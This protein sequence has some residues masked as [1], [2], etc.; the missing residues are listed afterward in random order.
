MI[1][2]KT[3]KKLL[4]QVPDNADVYAYEGEDCGIVFIS[5]GKHMFIRA[6][7][8]GDKDAYTEGFKK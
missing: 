7:E 4:E 2:A 8:S 1:K 3:L 5:K 6:C